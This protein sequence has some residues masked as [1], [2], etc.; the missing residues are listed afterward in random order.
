MFMWQFDS[1]VLNMRRNADVV[2]SIGLFSS[3][4]QIEISMLDFNSSIYI[5]F[6]K[7]TE[8]HLEKR[9]SKEKQ[10]ENEY[11]LFVLRSFFLIEFSIS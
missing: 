5:Y 2:V 3:Y 10:K 6:L 4:R 11:G 1:S 9:D 8:S 7:W